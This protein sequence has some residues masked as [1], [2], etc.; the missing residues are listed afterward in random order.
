[1]RAVNAVKFA[2]TIGGRRGSMWQLSR[3]YVAGAAS[4]I[5]KV[6]F[7]RSETGAITVSKEKSGSRSPDRPLWVS[8]SQPIN[9]IHPGSAILNRGDILFQESILTEASGESGTIGNFGTLNV[10][11]SIIAHN[12]I[13][14]ESGEF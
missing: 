11:R 14:H 9:D 3:P 1:M 6:G 2:C 13:G 5:L 7:L 10:L 4:T 8:R 12:S